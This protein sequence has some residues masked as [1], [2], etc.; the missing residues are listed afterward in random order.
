MAKVLIPFSGGMNSTYSLYRY[1]NE[2]THDVHAYRFME[3]FEPQNRKAVAAR[4]MVDWLKANVRDF[5]FWEE[6]DVPAGEDDFYAF[7]IGF[8]DRLKF[9][10]GKLMPRWQRQ[11]DIVERIKPD[12]VVRGYAVELGNHDLIT[13]RLSSWREKLFNNGVDTYCS[14][15]LDL[16]T[17]IDFM[18][19]SDPV[20]WM[21]EVWRP[22]MLSMIGRFE[23][24]EFIPSALQDLYELPCDEYHP[25]NGERLCTECLEGDLMKYR[26]D[27]T[28]RE[29]DRQVATLSK[30]WGNENEA[31][32]ASF[33][34]L[35]A[36][37]YA[38]L[39][40]LEGHVDF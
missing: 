28:G 40:L 24:W 25:P 38:L 22:L 35:A 8:E 10:F 14:G 36:R 26:T 30:H 4:N 33:E 20:Q 5:T 1:L 7:R 2:T 19:P 6:P 15:Q 21:A 32:P 37:P 27:L 23:Q 18:N 13:V 17:P 3:P 29:K 16:D 31:D 12:A 34:P 9:N 39:Q 11:V